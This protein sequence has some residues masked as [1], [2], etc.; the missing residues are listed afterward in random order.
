MRTLALRCTMIVLA[1]LGPSA[2]ALANDVDGPDDCTHALRDFGDAPE[3]NE[4]YPGVIGR[5]PTCMSPNPA[6][7]QQIVCA[8]LST[9]PGAIGGFI[10]HENPSGGPRYWLGCLAAGPPLGIDSESD[11]K[12]NSNGGGFSQCNPNVSIDCVEPSWLSFGQDECYGDDD[13][14]LS[15]AV[16]FTPCQTSSITFRAYNCLQTARVVTLNI[17]VDWNEDGDWNDN[18]ECAG[19]EFGCS[20]EWA[21]KNAQVVLPP[22]CSSIAS[23][24]FLAGPHAGRGWLRI[25]ISDDPVPDDY[26]WNGSAGLAGG[27]IAGGETEDYPVTIAGPPVG[28]DPYRDYGDA[29]EEVEAYPGGIVGH[30]PTCEF[31]GAPGTAEIECGVPSGP[32]P[33]VTGFVRHDAAATDPTKFWLGCGSPGFSG[34]DSESNG[35]MNVD[36]PM[37]LASRCD[38]QI[39]V[40]CFEPVWLNFGQDE[41]YGD[42]DAGVPAQLTFS[43]CESGSVPFRAFNC[44]PNAIDAFLNILVD[45]N[46]DGDWADNIACNT[47]A[48]ACAPEWAVRNV[49]IPLNPGCNG[50]NSPAF[51]IGD[52]AGEGWL[53]ITLTETPVPDDFPWNGSVS[54]PNQSFRA[55]ETEDYPVRIAQSPLGVR[56]FEPGRIVLAPASPNPARSWTQLRWSQPRAARVSLAVYD[57]VGRRVAQLVA[58]EMSAGAHDVSWSFEEDGGNPVRPGVYLAKLRIGNETFTTR[59]VRLR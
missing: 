54:M 48:G 36:P 46:E 33:G 19:P 37:G 40:D 21:I 35:K 22:G 5:F 23:P 50:L 57:A 18:F 39:A 24:A 20:H 31:A 30:F 3:G 43:T 47:P 42:A 11:G 29:P 13:A 49:P 59:I 9:P 44:S 55:G 28:C 4:A 16:T 14:G 45:W 51:Q 25:T 10:R 52:H 6:G 17:L 7:T 38:P 27:I 32:P 53:R 12:T 26:P 34:V 15:A 58:S 2:A 41:C 56:V 8:P 1:L